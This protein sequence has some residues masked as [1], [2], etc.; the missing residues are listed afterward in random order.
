MENNLHHKY[1]DTPIGWLKLSA[2]LNSLV[3]ISFIDL[4]KK[5]STDQPDILISTS[6]QLTEYFKGDRKIFDVNLDP[7]GTLFQKGV[8][9]NV[10][11]I[12]F[13]KTASYLDIAKQT[14]SEKN[15]RAVGMANG[16]NPIPIIIPCHRIIGSNG[17]LTGYAGGLER[18]RWLLHHELQFSEK[19]NLLF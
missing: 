14:G 5:N 9:E 18:K 17:K 13:G 4:P 6:L 12:D 19:L 10:S 7:S 3:S 15:T 16:K 2:S 11:Q 8:W 1:I